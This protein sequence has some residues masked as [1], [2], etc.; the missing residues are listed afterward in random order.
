MRQSNG[1]PLCFEGDL[2]IVSKASF[3]GENPR[4]HV[5]ARV[6]HD[7]SVQLVEDVF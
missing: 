7:D 2:N 1:K 6:G 4:R 5:K 3:D